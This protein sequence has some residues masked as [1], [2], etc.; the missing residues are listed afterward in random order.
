[1]KD[2]LTPVRSND[3]T[4]EKNYGMPPIQNANDYRNNETSSGS[5]SDAIWKYSGVTKLLL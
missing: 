4:L 2:I 3:E 1:M 5:V